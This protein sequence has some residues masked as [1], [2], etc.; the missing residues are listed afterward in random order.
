[1]SGLV[2]IRF[3]LRRIAG[4]SSRRRVAVVDRLAQARRPQL[5]ELARLVLGERLGRVEVERPALRLAGDPVEH[6]QVEGEALARGGA[7]GDDQVRARRRLPGA[8]LVRVERLDP[9]AAAAARPAPGRARPGSGTGFAVRSGSEASAT[10]RP[11]RRAGA[12][13]TPH[14]VSM[15]ELGAAALRARSQFPALSAGSCERRSRD[16]AGQ[17]HRLQAASG[18]GCGGCRRPRGPR[19]PPRR[20]SPTRARPPAAAPPTTRPAPRR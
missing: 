10:I 9:G 13:A 15:I 7:G 12:I 11:S 17:P 6:R 3:D 8:Q 2:R 18:R 14:C 4:R 1:M 5:G 16:L 19:G 20:P